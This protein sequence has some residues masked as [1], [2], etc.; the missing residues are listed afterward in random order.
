MA[1]DKI[2]WKERLAWAWEKSR[3][4]PATHNV[5]TAIV[6]NLLVVGFL[7]KQ[8]RV[9]NVQDVLIRFLATTC[10]AFI[11]TP[12]AL[13]TVK[14]LKA[15]RAILGERL[16]DVER[17][18]KLAERERD[19]LI[20][21]KAAVPR[22]SPS[23]WFTKNGKVIKLN[24]RN[25]GASAVFHANSV[26]LSANAGRGEIGHAQRLRWDR[27]AGSESK[28]VTGGEDNCTV[29]GVETETH[30]IVQV[31]LQAICESGLG[32]H[33]PY[34]VYWSAIW[35][36]EATGIEL[37]RPCALCEVTVTAEPEMLDGPIRKRFQLGPGGFHEEGTEGYLFDAEGRLR[38]APPDQLAS[39]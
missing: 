39:R 7:L 35:L 18:Q 20:A 24:V 17:R 3:L 12:I 11:I 31:T 30:P 23:I 34:Q 5:I 9:N 14:F 16:V 6:G 25:L 13:Y 36:P 10:A 21:E 8:G 2:T 38:E 37:S 19:L 4:F 15:P 29:A 33:Q 32:A 22:P 28:I 1:R 27:A 26:V